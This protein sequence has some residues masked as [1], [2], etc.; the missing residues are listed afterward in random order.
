MSLSEKLRQIQTNLGLINAQSPF[1]QEVL[2]RVHYRFRLDWNYHSH[3]IE[4]GTLTR[5]ET[6]TVMVGNI[7]VEGKPF[8]DIAE[9]NGHDQVVLEVLK[10]GK[11]ELSLSEK[12]IKE[13]HRAIIHPEKE[14]EKKLTGNWKKDPN[15]IINYKLE[16]IDFASPAD[17]PEQMHRLVDRTNAA[18]TRIADQ[19]PK[20]P[21]PVVL[22]A[23][24]HIDYLTIHP[25]FD[26]NGRTARILSNLLL[27][28]CGLPP[29]IIKEEHK[30]AYYRLLGD[31]QAYGGSR[32]LFYQFFADRVLE[33]L[34]LI[35]LA[36][37]GDLPEDEDEIDK[38][39]L[40]LKQ[41]LAAKEQVAVP[42]TWESLLKT[43]EEGFFPLLEELVSKAGSL[44]ELFHETRHWFYLNRNAAVA[45]FAEGSD[46]QQNLLAGLARLKEDSPVPGFHSLGFEMEFRGL[47]SSLNRPFFAIR[48]E[49][50]LEEYS[51]V[52]R[53]SANKEKRYPYSAAALLADQSD[54]VKSTVNGLIA[55]IREASKLP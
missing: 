41:E 20:A 17:V 36:L 32:D 16:K 13:I 52:L 11:G 2:K 21:H 42:K 39:I 45:Y 31:I 8:R 4:G 24:F 49:L 51:F 19:D 3:K 55:E 12:R 14:E 9:M 43:V 35:L 34:E 7:A 37:N 5:P 18:L 50:T 26:G 38:D 46:W 47:T 15:E 54:W 23:D 28:A 10:M 25:F 30:P 44:Q 53:G 1:A 29:V 40:L 22:A 27:I 33:S 6:R 48:L